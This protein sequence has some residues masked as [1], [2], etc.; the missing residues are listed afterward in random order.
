MEASDFL[1]NGPESAARIV[2]LAHGAGSPMDAPFMEFVAVALAEKGL[3]VVRFEFPYMRARRQTGKRGAPNSSKVLQ[4]SWRSVID[5]LG[6]SDRLA[7]GGKSM[8]GRIASMVADQAGVGALLCLGYP[9]HP[10]GRPEN[11]KTAHLAGLKTPSLILQGS[12]DAFGNRDEIQ[13]YTISQSI[14][15]VFL[16][17]GDHSFKPRKSSGRTLEQNMKEAVEAAATFIHAL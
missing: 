7:I 13:G 12:R 2:V 3:R 14:R 6:S 10:P 11:L 15:F 8:G 5:T 9:F 1:T 16:E 4:E 17:G